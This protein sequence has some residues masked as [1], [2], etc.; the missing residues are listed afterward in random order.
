MTDNTEQGAALVATHLNDGNGRFKLTTLGKLGAQLPIGIE[1]S[2]KLLKDFHHGPWR[3][4]EEK[5][6]GAWRDQ[7]K[8]GTLGGFVTHMMASLMTG[9]GPHTFGDDM[10]M[11]NRELLVNQL[12]L[13]DVMYMYVYLR[14][15]ALGKHMESVLPCP[16]CKMKNKRVLDLDGLDVATIDDPSKCYQVVELEDGV[17]IFNELRTS[18]TVRPPTWLIMMNPAMFTDNPALRTQ[19]M[20]EN[21]VCGAEGIESHNPIAILE[22]D[23]EEMSKRDVERLTGAIESTPGPR[24]VI[25]LEDC[26]R[27]HQDSLQMVDWA[28]DSF[29]TNASQS[30]SGK[31]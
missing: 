15:A 29:F 24:M 27:C 4:K 12:W 25:E 18:V 2:E 10:T 21:C 23:L 19:L 16:H 13:S 26:S 28:Y 14:K 22:P 3:F 20:I 9:I 30:P 7:N 5:A 8:G 11:V 6:L 31:T 1:V 17:V